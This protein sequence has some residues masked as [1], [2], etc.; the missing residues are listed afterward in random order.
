MKEHGGK[1]IDP[2]SPELALEVYAERH[3]QKSLLK[4]NKTWTQ[5]WQHDK[6]C[7]LRQVLFDF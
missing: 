6:V 1:R 3:F 5:V 2:N 7:A 4:A